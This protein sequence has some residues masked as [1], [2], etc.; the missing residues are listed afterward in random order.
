MGFDMHFIAHLCNEA[1]KPRLAKMIANNAELNDATFLVAGCHTMGYVP[2]AVRDNFVQKWN[3]AV[4]HDQDA[5]AMLDSILA[6]L[7]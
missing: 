4:G 1:G 2:D 3:K 6:L 5:G 7:Q